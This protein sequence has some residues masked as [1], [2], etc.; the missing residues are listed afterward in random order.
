M[1]YIK[2][3]LARTKKNVVICNE[4]PN[5]VTKLFNHL[6]TFNDDEKKHR[7]DKNYDIWRP[8]YFGGATDGSAS[9]SG[10][11]ERKLDIIGEE[12]DKR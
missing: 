7:I 6:L 2:H 3:H 10:A 1:F 5:D 12:V 8:N 9:G 4:V 11:K